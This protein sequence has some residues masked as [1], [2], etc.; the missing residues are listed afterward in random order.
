MSNKLEIS[1]NM[2]ARLN[3]QEFKLPKGFDVHARINAIEKEK[4]LLMVYYRDYVERLKHGDTGVTKTDFNTVYN[5]IIACDQSIVTLFEQIEKINAPTVQ[6]RTELLA[7][8]QDNANAINDLYNGQDQFYTSKTDVHEI[9][10]MMQQNH[11]FRKD[12]TELTLMS[13]LITDE[14][15]VSIMQVEA[16]PEPAPHVVKHAKKN[17]RKIPDTTSNVKQIDI[18][19]VKKRIKEVIKAKFKFQDKQ[20]CLSRAKANFMSKEEI[21][22]VIDS[23]NDLKTVMPSNYKNLSK[24]ALCDYLFEK[25]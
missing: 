12:L 11:A 15:D 6:K 3:G 24:N 9:V 5:R 19:E 17:K 23:D 25:N 22:K 13:F 21:I 2:R 10:K 1:R 4:Q 7:A 8:I 14:G 20:Q 18:E 16:E